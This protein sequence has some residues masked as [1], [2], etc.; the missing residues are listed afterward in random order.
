M[1]PVNTA[2]EIR[3][4]IMVILE[5][6]LPVGASEKLISTSLTSIGL[7]ISDS[8]MEIQLGYL[9]EKGY[10]TYSAVR[11]KITKISRKIAKLTAKGIDLIEGNIPPDPGIGLDQE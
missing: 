1:S 6:A 9:E 5:R 4:Y 3:H 11:D 8:E 10:I 2:P 7:M